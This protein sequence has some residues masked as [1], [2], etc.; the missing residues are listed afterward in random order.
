MKI[1]FLGSFV[2]D[3]Y[4]DQIETLSAAGNQ[5]QWNLYRTLQREHEMHALSY[6]SIHISDMKGEMDE[7]LSQEGI[8]LF[9]PKENGILREFVEFRHKLFHW[10]QWAD[11][12]ITYNVQYP[13]LNMKKEKRKILVLADYTPSCEEP[14]RK[15][16]YSCLTK[17]S[18]SRYQKMVL[19]SEGSKKY[20]SPEQESIIIPGAIRWDSFRN[21]KEPVAK[22]KII[23]LYSGVLNKVTGVDVLIK[24]FCKIKNEKYELVLCGQGNELKDE[25]MSAMQIDHRIKFRGYV[26][27]KEYY[28]LL[29]EADICIN[30]RNMNYKQNQY[31]FPSKLL[32]YI[33]AGRVVVSTK[34]VNYK[35]YMD[36]V[37]FT[38]CDVNGIAKAL[39]NAAD[40]FCKESKSVFY[41]NREF[42]QTLTWEKVFNSFL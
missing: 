25:I 3:V 17:K 27:K 24:S 5:F 14:L 32:E 13:W 36:Y 7:E 20:V 38:E 22:D 29:E 18:F 6:L 33:A 23:F 12:V 30:P 21:F 31:N 11:C 34:F 42:A 40:L 4:A 15:K 2:P 28:R 19:L 41:R 1:L 35:K 9:L 26:S 8:D 10:Y 37:I 39:D 16:I